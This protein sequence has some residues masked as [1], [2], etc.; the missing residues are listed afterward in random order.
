VRPQS[1][2][3]TA[4]LPSGHQQTDVP[5]DPLFEYVGSTTLQVT[6]PVTGRQ[7]R[8]EGRGARRAI[9]R[10]DAPSLLHIPGLRRVP[11]R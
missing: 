9:S 6:G 10:H 5:A 1:R 7:Y 4:S 3:S 2:T 8:F 11:S